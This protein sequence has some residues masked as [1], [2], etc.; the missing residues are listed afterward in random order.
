MPTKNF[1]FGMEREEE[2]SVE[3]EEGKTLIIKL[4]SVGE[5]AKDGTRK[6]Y[7]EVNGS[8]REVT[9]QDLSVK[10]TAKVKRK[11]E[12]GNLHHVAA[13][14]PG[15]VAD[16]KVSK[17]SEVK[18]GDVLMVLEAMKM[19]VNVAAPQD[20]VVAEVPVAKGDICEAG[21]LLAVFV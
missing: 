16:V 7:F 1:L 4:V 14:I 12:S 17:G 20:A 18:R 19:Q 2:I 13:A 21:D 5:G 9:V 3:I 6:L 8:P 15:M 11:A 10:T